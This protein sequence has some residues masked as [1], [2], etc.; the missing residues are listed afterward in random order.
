MLPSRITILS[1]AVALSLSIGMAEA[2]RR[3]FTNDDFRSAAPPA[4]PAAT[5][6][7]GEQTRIVEG[8]GETAAAEQA[9]AETGAKADLKNFQEL[10]G[11]LRKAYDELSVRIDN[12]VDPGL[13]QR[14]ISMGDCMSRLLVNIQRTVG[15]LETEI[16][17]QESATPPQGQPQAASQP[18]AQ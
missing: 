4:A 2:Q 17:E 1:F 7:D 9:P 13:K 15:E 6:A 5:E 12:T 8:Q 10:Q 3:V 16:K 14:W 18:P 11:A